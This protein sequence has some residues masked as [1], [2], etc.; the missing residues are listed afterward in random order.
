MPRSPALPFSAFGRRLA[1][2]YAALAV[3]LVLI[4]AGVATTIAFHLYA[5][6]V[7]DALASSIAKARVL[8]S[9][10]RS[11]GLTLAQYGPKIVA[12]LDRA[13]VR[14]FFDIAPPLRTA[15]TVPLGGAPPPPP[16]RAMRP[17]ALR[18]SHFVAMLF[19]MH[20]RLLR[21]PGGAI[22]AVPNATSLS[23]MVKVYFAVLV[24]AGVVAVILAWLLGLRITGRAIAP[25]RNVTAALRRIAGGDLT[26]EALLEGNAEFR[27][28]TGAYND[29]AFRLNAAAAERE[30]NELQMR[31][32]IADAG[33]ELRTPL[34]V[35]MGYLD[36]LQ[37]GTIHE[38][39]SIAPLYATMLAE[40][41]RMRVTIDKL[42]FLARLEQPAPSAIERFDLADIARRVV[43]ALA[44][45]AGEGRLRVTHEGATMVEADPGE[46]YE[47]L[48]NVV[49]N[50]I[51]YAP[52]SPIAVSVSHDGTTARVR[53]TDRG[54][55]I[56]PAEIEHVFDRFYRGSA[57]TAA[58]G[59][60]IE[61]S[62]LGLAIAK[63]ALERAGGGIQIQSQPNLETHVDLRLPAR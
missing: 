40:S 19:G 61:G 9:G 25:L 51:R 45:L 24:P 58:G 35:V 16:R 11:Q 46:I 54:P 42:I 4:V 32:F 6:V 29:V 13:H 22:V 37:S 62:G 21:V 59:D 63:R 14:V 53:V 20:P 38:P 57:P 41:R 49:E 33:H 8:A 26:P 3:A 17:V 27:D 56:A 15:R 28:L 18:S 52:G 48:K 2:G 50:A 34:T 5:G 1:F 55:G 31:Q 36:M 23:R 12:E 39:A 7:N 47:A 60:A 30:R 44:P 43:D 10:Y